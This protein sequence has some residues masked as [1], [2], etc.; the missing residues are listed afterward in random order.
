M[1]NNLNLYYI[2]YT[3]ANHKNI[4]GAAKE[5]YISQPAISKAIS[6]LESG[7]NTKLFLRSSRGV[8]LTLEGEMLYGQVRN[9]FISIHN[10]EEQLK[11]SRELGVS[12][13]SIGVSVTLCKYIL[14]PYLQAFV[15]DNPHVKVSITCHPSLETI[16]DIENG[17][18]DIGL[19]GMG[20]GTN[21]SLI[22]TPV[23]ELQDTFVTTDRYLENFKIREGTTIQDK[24][25]LFQNA[26]FMM[27]NKE[28]VSRKYVD[29]YLLNQQ[30]YMENVIEI[31]TMDLLIEL[32]KIDLG[33]A[34]VIKDF[35]RDELA[36]GTLKELVFRRSI[37]KRR[38]GFIYRAD[39]ELTEPMQKFLKYFEQP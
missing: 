17:I 18:S 27:L 16:R 2:F 32:A 7:L 22:Y 11:K 13:L 12:H 20:N 5:L 10:G 30:I 34:C 37:P 38:V 19:V 39:A 15:K 3:V 23:M 1:E 25:A 26:T 28:N 14:L 8:T 9:A 4:S 31:N 6:K 33:I 36:D 24:S 35:V 29:S 21:S